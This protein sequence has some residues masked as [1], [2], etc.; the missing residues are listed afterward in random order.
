MGNHYWTI[1]VLL[2]KYKAPLS[3]R[4]SDYSSLYRNTYQ[5][6][7]IA[8][9]AFFRNALPFFRGREGRLR[10]GGAGGAF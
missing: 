8:V 3:K 2:S 6:F 1:L 5:T 7:F 9:K 4:H 10:E